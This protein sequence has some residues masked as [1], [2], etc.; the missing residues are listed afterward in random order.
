VIA[1]CALFCASALTAH[2]VTRAFAQTTPTAT[3]GNISEEQETDE[4]AT[5]QKEL[6]DAKASAV[7]KAGQPGSK[8]QAPEQNQSRPS[9]WSPSLVSRLSLGIGFFAVFILVCVTILLRQQSEPALPEQ[10]LRVFGILVIIFASVFLVIAGY[11]DTQITPVIGLLGT[12]AG[13]LLGRRPDQQTGGKH[14]GSSSSN[15][16]KHE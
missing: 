13:Y 15:E 8:K 7:K 11:S 14:R 6:S 2:A 16:T 10:I 3:A 12:I 1:A 9:L 4:V 5:A